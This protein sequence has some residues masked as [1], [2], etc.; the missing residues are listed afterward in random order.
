VLNSHRFL[1]PEEMTAAPT[2]REAPGL[3]LP[4]AAI[5]GSNS[6]ISKP[7]AGLQQE[8][9]REMVS[10]ITTEH[11]LLLRLLHRQSSNCP[12]ATIAFHGDHTDIQ[13]FGHN[14]GGIR[15]AVIYKS[16]LVDGDR[17]ALDRCQSTTH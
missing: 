9:I 15:G 8:V 1:H 6:L 16:Q 12:T 17:L 14:P 3:D 4:N 2:V 11:Q 13:L 10:G 5:H 7:M